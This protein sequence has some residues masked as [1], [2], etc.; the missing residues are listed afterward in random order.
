MGRVF[1]SYPY[2]VAI[3]PA[4]DEDEDG[5][6][7]VSFDCPGCGARDIYAGTVSESEAE[8]ARVTPMFCDPCRNRIGR[9]R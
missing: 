1:G 7:E 9:G 4:E 8:E 5:W 3:V 2:R 6:V